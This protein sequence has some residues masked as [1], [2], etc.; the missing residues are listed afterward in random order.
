MKG[1]FKIVFKKNTVLP[2]I[3]L[4]VIGFASLSFTNNDFKIAK[5][6]DIFMSL[7]R[8]VQLFYVDETNPE[9][10]INNSIEGLLKDLDPY[11]TFIPETDIDEFNFMTTGEYGGIGALVRKSGDYVIISDPYEG[12]PA[13]LAGIK[14]GDKLLKIDGEDVKGKALEDVSNLLKGVPN[15]EIEIELE[16]LGEKKPKK[17]KFK[18]KV[19]RI[20]NVPYFGMLTSEIGY[21][22]IS[23]FT[24]N[25]GKEVKNALTKLK[26][27]NHAKSVVLDFRSNPGG[28]LIEAVNI[29]NL[30][31]ERGQEVVST[32]GKVKQWNATY[33]AGNAPYDTEIP[34]VVMVNRGSASASEIVSGA[35]QD[36]DR[37][38][39][40]GE[41]TFGKGLVQSTRDLSYNTKL[42]VT[43]A[44]YYIPSGR[45]IQALDFSNRNEDGSVG[46]IPDSLIS[47]YTTKNGRKVY[48]GGGIT[49]DIT[50][51]PD[52]YGKI[53]ISMFTKNIFFDYAT[54]FA[55]KHA[56]IATPANFKI[57]E[58]IFNDF[59]DFIGDK[60]FDYET[61]SESQLKELVKKAKAEKYYD[62][63]KPEFDKL[64]EKLA[65]DKHKDIELFRDEI[66]DF[67][68][69]EIVSRYYY[70]SGAIEASL[71]GDEQLEKAIEVLN[72]QEIYNSILDGTY[73][74]PVDDSKNADDAQAYVNSIE[75]ENF[76]II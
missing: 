3:V 38:V 69:T 28:L 9:E 5:N 8:E 30:F 45:C 17:I 22:R 2:I 15:T 44:K 20:N 43:T 12:F 21:I 16:R 33:K 68:R 53:S 63:A 24:E 1:K 35:M 57:T 26:E 47:E 46:R 66:E 27:E 34:V 32:K 18:R 59:I 41:R 75:K 49:P 42:K 76:R 39:V 56:S 50:V 14:A 65:H 61:Q 60:D 19:I 72:N 51:T 13:Q 67:L 10:L 54:Y 70:Q 7:F 23:G 31:I 37:G 52:S 25:A 55:S 4:F 74:P 64:Q 40:I 58:D 36:L 71:K 73:I 29:T 11:T 6:L 48:D 62:L